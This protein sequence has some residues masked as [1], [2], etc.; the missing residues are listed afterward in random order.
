MHPDDD[1]ES[2]DRQPAGVRALLHGTTGRFALAFGGTVLALAAVVVAL[3]LLGRTPV[4]DAA[5]P[6]TPAPTASVTPSPTV[7]GP[8]ATAVPPPAGSVP[9][10][11]D[12][13][14]VADAPAHA[15]SAEVGE[16]YLLGTA[17]ATWGM[18]NVR[19]VDCAQPHHGQLISRS[20]LPEPAPV[21][22]DRR[23]ADAPVPP[24]VDFAIE[25]CA[26]SVWTESSVGSEVGFA[27]YFPANLVHD[28]VADE[29]M[30]ARETAAPQAGSAMVAGG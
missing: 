4:P 9:P 24:E 26:F 10:A 20:A 14:R 12:E 5:E 6:R 7:P 27:L 22:V 29:V 13:G 1:G 21:D 15:Q 11:L 23:P 18:G 30:C 2:P 8:A 3:A 17:D 16:C 25:D 19:F 28:G